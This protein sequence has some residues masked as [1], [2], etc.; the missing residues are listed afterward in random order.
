MHNNKLARFTGNY[1]SS[2][3]SGTTDHAQFLRFTDAKIHSLASADQCSNHLQH[4]M[5]H[6][7]KRRSITDND[8]C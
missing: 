8:N 7:K 3:A 6:G 1:W 2:C 4:H 5:H